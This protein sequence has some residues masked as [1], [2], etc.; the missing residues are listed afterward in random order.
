MNTNWKTIAREALAGSESGQL[1]F[2]QAVRMLMEAGF[3]GYAID[4]RRRSGTYYLPSGES[5]EW[6][7]DH[8]DKPVAAEFDTTAVKEAIREAQMMVPGFTYR[9]FC[10][11]VADAGCAGY[12][13][14]SLGKRVLYYGRTGESHTEY[15]PGAAPAH[16]S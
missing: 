11:I 13:V 16:Q 9:G 5:V 7:M 8:S 14:S 3:D 15:F 6:P 1:T 12:V 4:F 10:S 2:P